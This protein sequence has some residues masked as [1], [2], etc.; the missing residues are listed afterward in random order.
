MATTKP[1]TS[2]QRKPAG[3]KPQV[4]MRDWSSDESGRSNCSPEF[5]FIVSEIHRIILSGAHD[6][7]HGNTVGVARVIA[8]RLAHT[9]GFTTRMKIEKM[10][11]A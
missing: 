3:P 6:L 10:K 9:Y 5:N 1:K 11:S 2:K 4:V 8:A 7:L